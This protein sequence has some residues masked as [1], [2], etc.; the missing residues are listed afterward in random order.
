MRT[1]ILNFFAKYIETE[2]GIIYSEENY[3]QLQNR[4]EEIAKLIGSPSVENLFVQAQQNISG[5]FKQLLLD[6]A[7]NNE[8]SFFR[9]NKVFKAIENT[10][11]PEFYEK[12]KGQPLQIWSAASSTGQEGVSL[13][14][15]MTEWAI[16]NG[17]PLPFQII[18]SDISERVLEKARSGLY[19]QLE[20]QR[21]LPAP[22]LIKY[23]KKEKDDYWRT[24]PDLL[25][26]ID[27]RKQNLK[28]PF[29][30]TNRFQLVLCRNVLIYQS[31][32]SKIEILRRIAETLVPG[33]YLILG[34]GENLYGLSKDFE[35]T[36][37][38]G[39]V[40]FRKK[41]AMEIAS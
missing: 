3:F 35:Q 26:N 11:V 22:L 4:L 34:S 17:K 13:A 19:S 12:L 37:C 39:A 6:V 31:L 23:F 2:L 16:K 20:I 14:I 32:D 33:G 10:V 38:D 27:Y 30:F 36:H 5:A 18:G 41:T 21:G 7:T 1:D 40:I 8:T 28:S 9:D 24:S 15:L 25:R 29:P